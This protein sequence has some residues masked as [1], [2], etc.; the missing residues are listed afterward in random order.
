MLKKYDNKKYE[1]YRDIL[2]Q[3]I[4]ISGILLVPISIEDVFQCEII[5]FSASNNKKYKVDNINNMIYIIYQYH[6]I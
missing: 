1:W 4:L 6:E 5:I 3:F 2:S